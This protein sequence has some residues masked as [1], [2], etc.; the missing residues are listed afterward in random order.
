MHSFR[1]KRICGQELHHYPY[2]ILTTSA[3][4]VAEFAGADKELFNEVNCVI[5]KGNGIPSGNA[6]SIR[7]L[8]PSML[9]CTVVTAFVEPST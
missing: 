3:A 7:T 1:Q 6:T 9:G 2:V 8:P 4:A 5:K